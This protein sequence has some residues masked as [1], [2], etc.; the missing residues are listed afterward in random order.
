MGAACHTWRFNSIFKWLILERGFKLD[1]DSIRRAVIATFEWQT[2]CFTHFHCFKSTLNNLRSVT[3]VFVLQFDE[4]V[5]ATK[6]TVA[7]CHAQVDVFYILFKE[8]HWAVIKGICHQTTER[9]SC[10]Y[11]SVWMVSVF[12]LLIMLIKINL[13]GFT[14]FR[15]AG[16]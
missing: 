7:Q 3:Q 8:I 15:G 14:L 2:F 10:V 5:S 4:V 16:D 1:L 12:W 6:D 9:L 13:I 11:N